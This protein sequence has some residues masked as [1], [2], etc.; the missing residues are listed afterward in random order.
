MRCSSTDGTPATGARRRPRSRSVL[1]VLLGGALGALAGPTLPVPGTTAAALTEAAALTS[2]MTVGPCDPTAWSQA[3][4]ALGPLLEWH[5]EPA[6][7]RNGDLQ[8]PGLLAC[9]PASAA[10][11][12]AGTVE[13]GL[14][15]GPVPL[16]SPEDATVAVLVDATAGAAAEGELLAV[17]GY[18]GEALRLVVVAGGGLELRY[19]DAV[20]DPVVLVASAMAPRATAHLVAVTSGATGSTLYV[21]GAPVATGPP[22]A[23]VVAPMTLTVGAAAGSGL[24]GADVVVDEVLVLDQ[25]L[26]AAAVA[27][28]ALADTW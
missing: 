27:G 19:D 3:V 26:D 9:D 20:G 22:G 10:W 7:L 18:G 14:T 5:F 28:L 6:A 25:V 23:I 4:A 24:A 16:V 2:T 1:V 11:D 13:G 21:D 15:S 8:A 12:L 17:H